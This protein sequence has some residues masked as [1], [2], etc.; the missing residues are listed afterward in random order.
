MTL[1]QRDYIAYTLLWQRR[2]PGE[3]ALPFQA[4]AGLRAE[5]EEL[6]RMA[7]EI[8][9]QRAHIQERLRI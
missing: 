4:Y 1:L 5:L 8:H 3:P 7:R 6:E 9:Q 2:H